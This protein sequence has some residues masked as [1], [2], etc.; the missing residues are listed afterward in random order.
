MKWLYGFIKSKVKAS[1]KDITVRNSLEKLMEPYLKSS[2]GV[3]RLVG[4][5]T[6]ET[7]ENLPSN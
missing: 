1:K 2:K 3:N 7:T 6:V 5:A 4:K